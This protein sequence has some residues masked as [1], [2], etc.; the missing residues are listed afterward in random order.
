MCIVSRLYCETKPKESSKRMNQQEFLAKLL[1]MKQQIFRF[2]MSLLRR[3]DEAEDVTQDIFE[4]LWQRRDELDGVGSV[5]GFVMRSVRNLCLDRLRNERRHDEKLQMLGRDE[6]VARQPEGFDLRHHMA[7]VIAK[8]P[9]K[10]QLIIQLRDVE[11]REMDEI[12]AVVGD[13]EP[14]VRVTLSRA[15]K[16]IREELQKIMNYGL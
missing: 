14:T 10:Q 1:P 16:K 5:E 7:R 8:L 4:R 15:R 12:A 13:D 3:Q 6:R 2:A 11:G 9:E